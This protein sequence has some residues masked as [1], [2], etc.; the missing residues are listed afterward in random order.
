LSV[1]SYQFTDKKDEGIAVQSDQ[2]I[3]KIN[4]ES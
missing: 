3:K 2:K 4:T 1:V